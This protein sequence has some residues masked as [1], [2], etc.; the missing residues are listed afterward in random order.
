MQRNGSKHIRKQ[1]QEETLMLMLGVSMALKIIIFANPCVRGGVTTVESLNFFV[2]L[3]ALPRAK[4][5]SFHPGALLF[6]KVLFS[7]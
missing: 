7:T 1:K 4:S 5:F 3:P 2:V 6:C